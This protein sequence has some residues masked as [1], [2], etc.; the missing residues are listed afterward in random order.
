MAVERSRG[1]PREFEVDQ[2]L[3]MA[4]QVFW[5]KGYEHTSL[6]DLVRAM[7]LSK[8]SFYQTFGS[9]LALYHRSIERYVE[10]AAHP[11]RP[12]PE[13]GLDVIVQFFEMMIDGMSGPGPRHGC[14]IGLVA[15]E[16]GNRDDGVAERAARGLRAVED[17]FYASLRAAQTAGEIP[18]RRDPRKMAR[19]LT[20][21]FY[22]IQ[23]MGRARLDREVLEDVVHTAL[24][25]LHTPESN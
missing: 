7:N 9:K 4:T 14:Y 10:L 22:G 25:Q 23:I 2:A 20:S 16:M 18:T 6:D 24:A 13:P 15:M 19:A 8:S 1:R 12:V 17:K 5:A 21:T 3:D 11:D